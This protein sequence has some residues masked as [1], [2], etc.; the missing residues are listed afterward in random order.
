M[1]LGFKEFEVTNNMIISCNLL[2]FREEYI[3]PL[4]LDLDFV[5]VII[6]TLPV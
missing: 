6:L 4:R 1:P 5:I 3:M 2:N